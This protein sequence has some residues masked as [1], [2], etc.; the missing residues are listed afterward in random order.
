MAMTTWYSKKRLLLLLSTCPAVAE[1]DS[2]SLLCKMLCVRVTVHVPVVLTAFDLQI[3][4]FYV[5]SLHQPEASMSLQPYLLNLLIITTP[6]YFC[7]RYKR[8]MLQIFMLLEATTSTCKTAQ[9]FLFYIQDFSNNFLNMVNI[10]R[11][12]VQGLFH[13]IGKDIFFSY[14]NDDSKWMILTTIFALSLG[15][16]ESVRACDILN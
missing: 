8:K 7:V 13:F 15:M 5:N 6:R 2:H 11:V 9:N 3:V 16:C 1:K 10:Q 14:W 12:K 4:L